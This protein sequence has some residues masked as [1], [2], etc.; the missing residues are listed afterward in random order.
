MEQLRM[1][2]YLSKLDV[3]LAGNIFCKIDIIQAANLNIKQSVLSLPLII[4]HGGH[5][6]I[7]L[8]IILRTFFDIYHLP[9]SVNHFIV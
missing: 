3:Y 6:D 5:D 8:R 7:S 2:L 1:V 4:I 9:G